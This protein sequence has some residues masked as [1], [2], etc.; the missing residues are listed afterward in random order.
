MTEIDTVREY[1]NY[2]PDTGEFTW[3]KVSSDKSKVGAR[4]G[5]PRSENG[6]WLVT[7]KGKTYYAHRLAWLHVYGAMPNKHIDHVN[8]DKG[9]NR[10]AN[11]RLASQSDNCANIRAKRDNTSGVKNVHW[12]NTKRRWVAKVKHKGK[13]HHAGSF[14]DYQSAVSAAESARLDVH[15]EFASQLGCERD[16]AAVAWPYRS[17]A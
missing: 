9:D 4:A 16:A 10:I 2:S 7:L 8:G 13:T 14:R 6:Y 5:R 12:C 15:G 11:L 17:A 1:L 3:K